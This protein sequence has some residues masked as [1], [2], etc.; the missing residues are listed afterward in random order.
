M[1]I[2]PVAHADQYFG[3]MHA[4]QHEREKAQDQMAADFLRTCAKGD[5]NALAFFAPMVIDWDAAKR[6][7]RPAGHPMPKRYPTLTECIGESLDYAKGP[8]M[9]EAVQLILNV[10]YGSDTVNAPQQARA[11]LSRMAQTFTAYNHAD[12]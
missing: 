12:E 3:A 4:A 1:H 8:S 10:A 5:A 7:P 2:D 6:Q 11:L 9:T